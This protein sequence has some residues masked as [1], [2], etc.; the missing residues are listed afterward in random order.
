MTD[1]TAGLL[2]TPRPLRYR[3]NSH[4][5]RVSAGHTGT[6]A[7]AIPGPE[8]G[9]PGHA[10]TEISYSINVTRAREGYSAI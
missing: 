7:R 3:L 8:V 10:G 5:L 2:E 6:A 4:G 1:S 9:S